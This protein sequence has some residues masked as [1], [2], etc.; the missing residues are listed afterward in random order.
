M[1]TCH[2]SNQF[3]YVPRVPW[4]I[5]KEFTWQNECIFVHGWGNTSKC[6]DSFARQKA[7]TDVTFSMRSISFRQGI[8]QLS[9]YTLS[10]CACRVR[11]MVLTI[12]SQKSVVFCEVHSNEPFPTVFKFFSDLALGNAPRIAL[13]TSHLEW[14]LLQVI[15]TIINLIVSCNIAV[16]KRGG[17][18][19]QQLNLLLFPNQLDLWNPFLFACLLLFAII[20]TSTPNR[21]DKHPLI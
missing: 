5:G 1:S 7:N 12:M 17:G 3:L 15:E 4:E 11:F 20:T 8:C 18:W 10:V 16:R 19:L 6:C 13:N 9:R 21:H 2:G 14:G